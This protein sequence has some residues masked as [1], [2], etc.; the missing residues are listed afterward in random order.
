LAHPL[1]KGFYNV[2]MCNRRL[3]VNTA[4]G[5]KVLRGPMVSR[6]RGM[7]IYGNLYTRNLLLTI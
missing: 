2:N 1:M 4:L 6:R 3:Q 5:R 7:T